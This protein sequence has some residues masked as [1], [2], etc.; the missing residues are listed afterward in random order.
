MVG[1][2]LGQVELGLLRHLTADIV[3][4]VK[5]HR[6]NHR[7]QQ[8]RS[9]EGARDLTQTPCHRPRVLHL[10]TYNSRCGKAR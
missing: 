10:H 1:W 8:R 7:R 2:S 6:D 3:I 5:Q 9:D 4:K